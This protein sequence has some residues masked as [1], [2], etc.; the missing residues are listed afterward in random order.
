MHLQSQSNVA[1]HTVHSVLH[2]YIDY[3][4]TLVHFSPK[5]TLDRVKFSY[6]SLNSVISHETCY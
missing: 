5:E 2:G 6:N 4:I 3:K 1:V